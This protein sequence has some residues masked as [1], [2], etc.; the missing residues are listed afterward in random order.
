MSLA[1][2]SNYKT[3]RIDKSDASTGLFAQSVE[4][5]DRDSYD[6]KTAQLEGKTIRFSNKND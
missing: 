3:L 6:V 4:G 2:P 1:G 5:L